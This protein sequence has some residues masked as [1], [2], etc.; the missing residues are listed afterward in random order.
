MI[1]EAIT[2]A[3]FLLMITETVTGADLVIRF[4]KHNDY[5]IRLT[6]ALGYFQSSQGRLFFCEPCMFASSLKNP[7]KLILH[8]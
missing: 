3:D 4:S 6:W 1:T 7:A 5:R 8:S 2:V